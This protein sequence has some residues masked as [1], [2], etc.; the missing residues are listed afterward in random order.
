MTRKDLGHWLGT[1]LLP[2]FSIKMLGFLRQKNK[3]I[4]PD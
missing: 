4:Q 2:G 3:P 1:E